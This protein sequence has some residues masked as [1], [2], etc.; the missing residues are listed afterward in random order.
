VLSI[1][2]VFTLEQQ[3]KLENANLAIVYELANENLLQSIEARK[4]MQSGIDE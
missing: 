2:K 1:Q 4:S 3:D